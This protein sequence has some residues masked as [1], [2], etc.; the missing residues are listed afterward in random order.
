MV[1]N[2][3]ARFAA[4]GNNLLV[5]SEYKVGGETHVRVDISH[6]ALLRNWTRMTGSAG[7]GGWLRDE[8]DD[9]L[10]WRSLAVT[11]RTG[12]ASLGGATLRDN[13]IG[14]RAWSNARSERAAT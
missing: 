11:A 1:E 8:V 14:T 5:R 4:K 3:V 13:D 9:G 10:K 2:V 7:R 12:D 6:E